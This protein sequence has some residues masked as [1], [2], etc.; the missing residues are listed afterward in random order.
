MPKPLSRQPAPGAVVRHFTPSWFAVVMGTGVV[1]LVLGRLPLGGPLLAPLGEGLWW[2]AVLL[3]VA[4]LVLFAARLLRHPDTLCPMLQHP[5]QSMFLGALPMALATLV[6]GLCLYGLPRW[7]A[8]ALGWAHALWWLDVALALGVALLV[9]Y[10]MVTRQDHALER[11]TAIWL[12]PIVAPEV[13]AGAGGALAAQLEGPAAVRVLLVGYLL[14]GLSMTLAFSLMTLLLLRLV[15]HK[16]PENEFAATGWLPLGPLATGCLGL[17]VLGRAAPHA[18]AGGVLAPVAQACAQL[19]LIGGLALWG[20]GLWWLGSATLF[21]VRHWRERMRFNLGW[22]GF[23]FPPGVFVLATLELYEHTAFEL[24]SALG[25]GLAAVLLV[26]WGLVLTRTLAGAWHGE[27]FR[28][29]CLAAEAS[30]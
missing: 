26:V 15:L 24:F 13:A 20:A 28:A 18:L 1:A 16:L 7:G 22:W 2:A 29:P 12:L 27:L 23:I 6:A 3:F 21:T 9:P 4:F 10:L 19:G 17:L 8:T 25:Q 30:G 14:W 5:V 11:L